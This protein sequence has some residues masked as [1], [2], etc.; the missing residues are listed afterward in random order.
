MLL[1]YQSSLWFKRQWGKRWNC[2]AS[3]ELG[4]STTYWLW[5]SQQMVGKVVVSGVRRW[6]SRGS[7]CVQRRDGEGR[8]LQRFQAAGQPL[9]R[10]QEGRRQGEDAVLGS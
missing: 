7:K 6:R 5:Q 8:R 9:W 10:E 3:R 1:D 2:V 4:S